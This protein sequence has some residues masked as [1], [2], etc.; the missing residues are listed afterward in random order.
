MA[1]VFGINKKHVISNEERGE[2]LYDAQLEFCIMYK[3]SL[4]PQRNPTLL[5][6]MTTFL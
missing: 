2:I 4:R 5:I 6:E 1:R 3:I